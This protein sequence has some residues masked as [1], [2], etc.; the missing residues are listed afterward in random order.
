MKFLQK[1]ALILIFSMTTIGL[2]GCA[3][4]WWNTSDWGS[5]G[6]NPYDPNREPVIDVPLPGDPIDEPVT[7]FDKANY[8]EEAL[9]TQGIRSYYMPGVDETTSDTI[10]AADR[11]KF[12]ENAAYQY[13]IIAHYILHKLQGKYGSAVGA[14]TIEY[15][16]YAEYSH[17]GTFYEGKKIRNT[18]DP[19]GID[20]T[21]PAVEPVVGAAKLFATT[22]DA[23]NSPVVNVRL[24]YTEVPEGQ[25]NVCPPAE[26]V[27]DTNLAWQLNGDD[28][29][30]F[31]SIVQ[32]NLMQLALDFTSDETYT[33]SI[34]SEMSTNLAEI[35]IE[36]LAKKIDRLGVPQKADFRDILVDYIENYIIG[37]DLMAREEATISYTD[38]SYTWYEEVLDGY[39]AAG[40]PQYRWESRTGYYEML[41]AGTPHTFTNSE[42]YKFGYHDTVVDLVAEILGTYDTDGKLSAR[43]FVADYPQYTRMEA[44]DS[45]PF[46]FYYNVDESLDSDQRQYITAMGYKN[47]SSV[48]MYPDA[49]LNLEALDEYRQKME[50]GEEVDPEYNPYEY[51][52]TLKRWLYDSLNICIESKNEITVDVYLRLHLRSAKQPDGSYTYTDYILH[53]TRMNTDPTLQ[54]DYY[55]PEDE[56]F[57]AKYTDDDGNTLPAIYFDEEKTNSRFVPLYDLM[58]IDR[59]NIL[60]TQGVQNSFVVGEANITNP[61]YR[62]FFH[63]KQVLDEKGENVPQ[64]KATYHNLFLGKLGST[65]AVDSAKYRD[66]TLT[67][68]NFYGETVDL[69]DR[70]LCQDECSFVEYIFDVQ[71][72]NTKPADYDYSFKFNILNCYLFG[73]D[74]E[75]EE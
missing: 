53:L 68:T 63:E 6:N 44:T 48:V 56:E 61:N 16:F 59:Y 51:D 41:G 69:S 75:E 40:N 22:A 35:E 10:L 47:Y 54:Y 57:K 9:A 66:T 18:D 52:F 33:L 23:I 58:N 64:D 34:P 72:D 21:L 3:L 55:P 17:S 43:G 39:D 1:I 4:P 30:A 42:I 37:A 2:G 5:G 8:Q 38:P 65:V 31:V 71:K 36:K 46:E 24:Q 15:E 12:R 7:G 13:E 50:N 32:L 60:V 19:D 11:A 27:H 26:A 14:D 73:D 67:F 70:F 28:L 62:Q 49:S 74:T 29:T 45:Q 20:I 25:G